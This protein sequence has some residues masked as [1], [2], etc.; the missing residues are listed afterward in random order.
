[1]DQQVTK[2]QLLYLRILQ[3]LLKAAQC[4]VPEE[5]LV[6]LLQVVWDFCPCFLPREQSI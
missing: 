5:Q 2:E 1:M 3:Q 6:K 4:S